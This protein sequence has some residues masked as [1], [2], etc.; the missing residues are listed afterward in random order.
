MEMVKKT[1]SAGGIAR[2]VVDDIVY[3]V[4]TKEPD[5]TNWVLPKGHQ[6]DGETLEQTAIREVE[7]ETGLDNIKIVK[8]LGVK[9]RHSYAKDEYKT[10]HYFLFD[11]LKETTLPKECIDFDKILEPRWFPIDNLPELFWQTQKDIIQENF[12]TIKTYGL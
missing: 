4:L 2:K 6:E 10:I 7:E 3:I 1:I 12:N 9:Q 8:K 11:C 5:R